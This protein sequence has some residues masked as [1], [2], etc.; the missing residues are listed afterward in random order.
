MSRRSGQ[1]PRGRHGLPR[2]EI[3]AS[4]RGRLLV[5]MTESV[6]ENGYVK[7]TV[8]DVIKRAGV[9][10]ETF[11]E[12]FKDKEACFL[13][14][15]DGAAA[16]LA[17]GVSEVFGESTDDGPEERLDRMLGVYLETLAAEPAVARTCLVEVYAAGAPAIAKRVAVLDAF[18]ALVQHLSGSEDRFRCEAFVG[19]VSS[20]VTVRL[21]TG[22][23]ATLPELHEPLVALGRELL[24]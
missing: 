20:M 21:A 19:A 16:M 15:L 10:R 4:Q 22:E 24:L 8:A 3:L 6:A 11:Y 7:A 5:A 14:A 12:Q 18:V 9:S 13:D 23:H 1:L 2:A 17:G